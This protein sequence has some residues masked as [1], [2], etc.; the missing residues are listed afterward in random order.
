MKRTLENH[1]IWNEL[2]DVLEQIDVEYLVMRHLDSCHYKLSGYWTEDEFYEEIALIG[3]IRARLVSMSIGETKIKHSN[4][5]NHWIRLHCEL[6][7]DISLLEENNVDDN[8]DIGE[9]VLILDPNLEIVDENWSIDVES[10]FVIVKDGSK[11]CLQTI[12]KQRS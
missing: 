9:L 5:E 2:N 6:K 10:P 3:P 8:S 7:H 11:K 12:L 4:Y 1:H